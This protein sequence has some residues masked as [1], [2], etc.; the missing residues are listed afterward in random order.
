MKCP[1]AA[2]ER[3]INNMFRSL[4]TTTIEYEV[5]T[6]ME[7][8]R[9]TLL[10]FFTDSISW[11]STHSIHCVPVLLLLFSLC[12]FS[13]KFSHSNNFVSESKISGFLKDNS[14]SSNHPTIDYVQQAVKDVDVYFKDKKYNSRAICSGRFV[15]LPSHLSLEKEGFL[16]IYKNRTANHILV[17]KESIELVWTSKEDDVSLFSLPVSFPSP[18]KSLVKHFKPLFSNS[19]FHETFFCTDLGSIPLSKIRVFKNMS[20]TYKGLMDGIHQF[21]NTFNSKKDFLYEIHEKGLCGSPIVDVEGGILGFHVSGSDDVNIG[22]SLAWSSQTISILRDF[23]SSESYQLDVNISDKIL[24]DSGVIKFVNTS[25]YGSNSSDSSLAPT[26]LFNLY[27]VTRLPAN[28]RVNGFHTVKDM[29]KKS[30]GISSYVSE[31]ELKFS[32]EVLKSMLCDFGDLTERQVVKGTDFLA[33]LNK[34]SSSGFGY[35]KNKEDYINFE[36]GFFTPLFLD[37]LNNFNNMLVS[38]KYPVEH[39]LWIETLKDEIR[40]EE[41]VNTP[42]TFRVGTL[43]NQVLTK[44]FFGKMVEHIISNRN[45]N[46]IMVGVN[47]FSEWDSIF[48]TLKNCDIVFA[49]DIKNWD[50]SMLPQVQ[51][52]VLDTIMSFYKGADFSTA[53]LVLDSIIHSLVLVQD[54]F[55]MTTHSMP[56]GSFLTAILNSIVNKVY[57]AI[58]YFRNSCK[59]TVN[60]FWNDV[61]DYVYG[62]DKLNGI[63][64]NK[65]VNLNAITMRSFFE[66]IGMGF[67]DSLKN[68]IVS[69]SQDLS[70]VTFLKRYFCYHNILKKIMFPLELRTIENTLSWFDSKKVCDDVMR[71]KIHAVQREFYLHPNREFLLSDFYKRMDQRNYPYTKLT[72]DYLKY[73]YTQEP[74]SISY[75][76]SVVSLYF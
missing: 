7:V 24:Q 23:L 43:L 29:A 11:I 74:D 38:N 65:S 68:P 33:P 50:G 21:S 47:P 39:F 36:D 12:L 10:S 13:Y 4:Y 69:P 55:Y 9:D 25:Y 51:R 6:V 76:S 26:P 45:F 22:V 37:K 1:N 48:Q 2:E 31:E 34:D 72:P 62:D 63:R 66:S 60:S 18:F 40:N 32:K 56:S 35:T 61:V 16:T 70:E 57:T 67:T 17:D 46:Q 73:L 49:G 30:F 58:W 44:K 3:A 71:D 5:P 20:A 19:S 64:N 14:V 41:K 52:M 59:P 42:R 75:C 8:W 53:K 15:I 54:D 27:P 28:L